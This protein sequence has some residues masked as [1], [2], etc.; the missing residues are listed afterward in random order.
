LVGSHVCHLY[1]REEVAKTGRVYVIAVREGALPAVLAEVLHRYRP[2]GKT[3]QTIAFTVVSIATKAI[4]D[5]ARV[6]FFNHLPAHC[7]LACAVILT[8]A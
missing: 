1:G 5:T 3:V 4:A 2:E 7:T 8:A 6:K